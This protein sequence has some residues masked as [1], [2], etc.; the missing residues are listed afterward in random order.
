MTK[1][2]MT[3]LGIFV[4]CI[5]GGVAAFA[6]YK[7]TNNNT[8][9]PAIT[10]WGTM[11]DDTFNNYVTQIN[12]VG[13]QLYK[14]NYVQK[15]ASNFNQDF[16]KALAKGTGPDAVLIPQD[17]TLANEDKFLLIPYTAFPERTFR[18]TY[19]PEANLYLRTDGITALPFAI[20]P[21]VMYYNRDM[22]TNA[23]IASVGTVSNPLRWSQFPVL[24]AK[25]TQKDNGSNI[26]KSVVALGQF[27]NIDHAREILG[28]L[29]L[30]AGNPVTVRSSDNTVSSALGNGI[31]QG[32]KSSSDALSFFTS[33]TDPASSAYSWNRSLP[34]SE[35]YFL[36]GNL[37]TYFGFASELRDIRSQNPNLN[38]DV[39]PVP[40]PDKAAVRTTYGQMYGFSLVKNSANVS[41]AYTILSSLTSASS[42]AEWTK[43]TYLP[44]VRRDMISAGT[45]DPYLAIFY[46]AALISKDWLDPNPQGTISIFQNM[47]QAVTSGSANLNNAIQNASDALDLSIKNI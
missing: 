7:G 39:A 47:V 20:D 3:I 5:V 18:D 6:F 19:V 41:T 26:R 31:F 15:T 29:L 17:M 46:D 21:L 28:T 35:S 23:G 22:F 25:I 27:G 4:L 10:V 1:F 30:Q 40:Q 42:L 13:G 38:F 9:L 32:T 36:A 14:I 2:Q 43:L 44:P 11:A 12:A 34:G 45:T 8:Q 16:V 24:G 33:F 37:A